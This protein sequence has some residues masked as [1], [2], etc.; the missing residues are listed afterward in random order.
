[1]SQLIAIT[2]HDIATMRIVISDESDLV[3]DI[4][5]STVRLF[6]DF[7]NNS[8]LVSYS[9]IGT[10]SGRNSLTLPFDNVVDPDAFDL[11]E[12]YNYM[13]YHIIYNQQWQTTK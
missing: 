8:I 6:K 4:I 13:T 1:M 3:F 12:L 9:N 5:K 11:E 2:N 10:S 7:R